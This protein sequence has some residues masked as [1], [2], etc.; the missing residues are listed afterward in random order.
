MAL[1]PLPKSR[2][3]ASGSPLD[4]CDDRFVNINDA[5]SSKF[6]RAV[7]LAGREVTCTIDRIEIR[8]VGR[9]KE[10][11]PIVF[12]QGKQKGLILNRT[13]AQRIADI[14]GTPETDRWPGVRITLF[15]AEV[16]FQGQPVTAVR[17]KP[18]KNGRVTERS[19]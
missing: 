11:R 15:P 17:V 10:R 19:A 16:E 8:E 7:D 9:I 3:F 6:L 5:F 4:D 12:F 18:E 13:N 2:A 1:A 14:A